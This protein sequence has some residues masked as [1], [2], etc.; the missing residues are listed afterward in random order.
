MGCAASRIER[1]GRV[2]VC[3][4]RKK[5]MKQLVGYRGEF[6]DAQLAYLRALKNTGVTLRQF[7]ES[8]S[9][10]L[11]NTSHCLTLPPSPPSPLPPPPPPSFSPDP[12]KAGENGIIEAALD[13]STKINQDECSTPPPPT[14]SSSWTYW[15]LFESTSPLHHP[16]QS[17]TV[18]PI[19][20]ESWAESKMQFE[21][22]NPGEEL[23][24]GFAINTLPERSL[25]REI[26]DD[27]SSIMSWYNKDS[28][29]VAMLVLKNNKTLEGIMKDLD[30]Y[31]LKA[32]AGGKEIAV[33]TDINI[34]NNS[35]PWK[36]NEN[37]RKRSNSAKVFSVLSW[38]WSSKSLQLARDAFQCRYSEPCNPG[39]H[40]ITLDKLYVAEQKLYKQVKEEE[41]TKL[42]LEKK[43]MLLQKQ[44]ENRD[45]TK[46][47]KIKSSVENLENDMTR[48][49]HSISTACSSILELIDEE[50]YPQLVALTS[51]LMEMWKM[52][53]KSH[54][55]QNHISKQLN[56]LTDNLSMD[57]TTES[58]LQATAQLETEVSFWYYSFC[59]L[60]KSQ[61]EYL[62]TLC[63]W[64]QLTDCL[65]SNQQ[66]SHCS[67]AVRRL[68]EEW[69][70]GFEKLPDKA[71]SETIKSFL[72]AI[73]SI[74][75]QQ[76]EEH[77]Q[78]KKSEKLQKRLQKELISLTEMEK[79]VE[80]SVLTLDMNSTLSP[81]HPLS[82]K[83][84]K[85]EA[86]KKRVD[87]E[88]GKH[89][90][91]VQ[92]SKTMILNNLKTSLPNVFQALMGF[93]KACV[94]VFEAIHGNSQPKIPCAS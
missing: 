35:L 13:E 73:Q 60:I 21:D 77:N 67:S 84:A 51:G 53:Y 42:E 29:D 32:S 91:S 54:Q 1:E 87:V 46:T 80:G 82:L 61:Q 56:H 6:A 27:S 85:T 26:V 22:E 31:F 55:F 93:S 45:W 28:I 41:V 24:E 9:L 81:K 70:L 43:L 88:K 44:D 79:K 74:I 14:A 49:Q 76:A 16:K 65:V 25:R 17:E 37:K 75:Q 66:Q 90:N 63:Q 64:I 83:R 72:L 20:E 23:V 62:R 86:L 15:D 19:Q 92:L 5:L 94:E 40:C 33:F 30:D 48:L 4:E 7:T 3:K 57:L 11:E 8:D 52:M 78:K 47:Q 68:C 38:S 39:A 34:G 59:R 71:A 58:R 2:Q 89:L 12:R 50:L 18:E 69:H 36:L 10:E